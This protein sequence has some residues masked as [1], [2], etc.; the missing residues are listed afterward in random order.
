MTISEQDVTIMKIFTASQIREL[1]RYTIEHEPITSIDLMER[2]ATL[3]TGEI[4][5]Y[6]DEKSPVVAFAGPG[7][8]GGDALAVVRMLRA[9]GI[10]AVAFLFNV[11]GKLSEDCQTNRDRLQQR[12]PEALKE[13]VQ[14][15]EPP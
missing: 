3:L 1:D 2:V 13:V 15:F 7:K 4:I 9:E 12:F 10:N 8:N 5:R 11:N 14:E 6:C